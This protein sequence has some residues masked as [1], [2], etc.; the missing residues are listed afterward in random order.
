MANTTST[1]NTANNNANQVKYIYGS[2]SDLSNAK[3]LYGNNAGYKFVDTSAQGFDPNSMVS[4]SWMLGGSAVNGNV[5]DNLLNSKGVTRLWGD[6]Q[7]GTQT[8][9]AN[10]MGKKIVYG[11]DRDLANAKNLYG[12][13]PNYQFVDVS[14]Q[15]FNPNSMVAGSVLLG[16]TG[17]NTNITDDMLNSLGVTRVGG[18]DEAATAD[19]MGS[20]YVNSLAPTN[21][22]FTFNGSMQDYLDQAQNLLSPQ[23]EMEKIK[24]NDN[25]D[26]QVENSDNDTLRRGLARSSYAGNRD[27]QINAYR[28]KDIMYADLANQQQVNNMAS[29]NYDKAYDRAYQL[30]ND[31]FNRQQQLYSNAN[32][33]YWQN[34]NFNADQAYKDQ[35]QSNWQKEFDTSNDHWQKTFDNDNYWKGVDQSNWQQ[36]FDNNNYWK[37]VDQSN[38]QQEFNNNNYWKGVDQSNWQQTFDYNKEKDAAT[39]DDYSQSDIVNMTQAKFADMLQQVKDGTA[40]TSDL[41]N[42]LSNNRDELITKAGYS[43][44]NSLL[45]Q[46]DDVSASDSGGGGTS[47]DYA[48]NSYDSDTE[49]RF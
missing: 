46:L 7:A 2:G 19:K 49:F 15:S 21:D 38:W 41:S 22:A 8:A 29:A 40:T 45:K 35:Q 20:S 33:N 34:K 17:V 5:T 16:G 18:K 23:L 42:W 3:S 37:G 31:Q 27:D 14:Q 11:S 30:Y 12:N 25:Y 9:L 26:T 10:A 43:T 13:N 24:I 6:N 44:Y 1:T 39:A 36:T 48:G 4:G 47:T 28:N 32:S